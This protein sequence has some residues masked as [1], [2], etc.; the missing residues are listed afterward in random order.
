MAASHYAITN[1]TATNYANLPINAGYFPGVST[2]LIL[3]STSI[4]TSATAIVLTA[5]QMFNGIAVTLGGATATVTTA[6]AA[7][8]YA[9]AVSQ[10]VIPGT[11]D[12]FDFMIVNQNSGNTTVAAGVGVTLTLGA[13]TLATNTA[14]SFKCVFAS[15]TACIV[16]G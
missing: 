1:N 4:P 6:A 16:Y 3:T 15:P 13:V 5:A 12:A 9:Y 7:A 10:G 2:G 11:L 14:K 8:L